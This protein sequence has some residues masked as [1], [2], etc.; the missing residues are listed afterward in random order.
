MQEAA[1]KTFK[2]IETSLPVLIGILMLLSLIK[3]LFEQYYAKIF[4]G[5]Y[6]LDPLI[7]ALAGSLSIGVPVASYVIG[8]ELIEQGVTLLAVTA[9]IFSWTTVG[10]MLLPFESENLGKRFA[11]FRNGFNFIFSIVIAVLVSALIKFV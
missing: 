4:T 10:L 6:L 1:K 3:L 7:G 8:G 5:N 9:F 11:L 2:N